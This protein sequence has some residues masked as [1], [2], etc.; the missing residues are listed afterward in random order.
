[1]WTPQMVRTNG[2]SGSLPGGVG[3]REF[4]ACEFP[5]EDYHW[6]AYQVTRPNAVNAARPGLWT[7]LRGWLGAPGKSETDP[8]AS[9]E[10]TSG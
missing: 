9:L 4:A 6:V 5:R 7:R 2:A 8:E 1:M 10:P 3:V